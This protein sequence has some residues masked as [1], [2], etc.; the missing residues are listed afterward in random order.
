MHNLLYLENDRGTS[1]LEYIQDRDKTQPY[2][3]GKPSGVEGFKQFLRDYGRMSDLLF[4]S[5]TA[6][7]ISLKISDGNWAR[8][9]DEMLSFLD[10]NRMQG[11]D[12]LPQNGVYINKALGYVIKVDGLSITDPNGDTKPLYS[13]S[14]NEFYVDWI[15]T[16]LRFENEQIIIAGSQTGSQWTTTGTVYIK[17][18]E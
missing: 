18:E 11:P 12:T 1:Y 2:Y 10:V 9:E 15:P 16:I 6:N 14:H 3:I 4:N 7:K 5:F 13:K 8:I 17:G